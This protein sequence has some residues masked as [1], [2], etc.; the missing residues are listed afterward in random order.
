MILELIVNVFST[1]YALEDIALVCRQCR[2]GKRVMVNDGKGCSTVGTN[3][4][5]HFSILTWHLFP[6]SN[7]LV[8]AHLTPLFP[9]SARTAPK[10]PRARSRPTAD[11]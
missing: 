4:L 7:R 1:Q 11:P 3:C 5:S 8:L 9:P 6:N 10:G 2:V